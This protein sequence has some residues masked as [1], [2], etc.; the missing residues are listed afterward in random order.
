MFASLGTVTPTE[1]DVVSSDGSSDGGS[2][3]LMTATV[4]TLAHMRPIIGHALLAADEVPGAADVAVVGY[5]SG[6]GHRRSRATSSHTTIRVPAC[7]PRS[8][9]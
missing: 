2:A 1:V 5:S 6:A 3:A 9:A 8:S 4:F 7:R